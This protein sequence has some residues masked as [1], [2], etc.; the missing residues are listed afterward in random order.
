MT[1]HV[2]PPESGQRQP[3]AW[4]SQPLPEDERAELVRLRTENQLLQDRA[5]GK[6][7]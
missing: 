6:G 3:A 5:A 7:G 2:S 4:N 1:G